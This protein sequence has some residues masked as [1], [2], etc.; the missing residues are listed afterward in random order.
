MKHSI[1]KIFQLIFA[2]A[3]MLVVLLGVVVLV[4]I[5]ERTS[6]QQLVLLQKI[7]QQSNMI[8]ELDPKLASL[9][10]ISF[11]ALRS[12]ASISVEALHANFEGFN[13]LRVIFK[14]PKDVEG[15]QKLGKLLDTFTATTKSYLESDDAART[16][17]DNAM[18][19]AYNR[20]TLHLSAMNDRVVTNEQ[21]LFD[22]RQL[23][24]FAIFTFSIILLFYIRQRQTFILND[25]RSLYGVTQG[26]YQIQTVEVEAIASRFKKAT[27]V[28]HN[29]AYIDPLTQIKNY[30]GL[31]HAFNNSKN[32]GM[33]NALCLCVFEIDDFE[34]LKQKYPKNF[35]EVVLKKVAF[36]L[37]LYEQHNDIAAIVEDSRFVLVLSRN[38]KEEGLEECEKVRQ[39]INETVFKIPQGEKVNVTISGG[40][41]VKPQNKS[42]EASVIYA[43]EVLKKAQQKGKNRIAQLRDYAEK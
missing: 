14:E 25:I 22:F 19:E 3:A 7:Q 17:T 11:A 35:I 37:S 16:Q 8:A 18:K 1:E 38:S 9:S 27:S 13:P 10:L 42:I 36:M 41:I 31:I 6:Q 21:E 39:S 28:Q 29:P 24:V 4:M 33:N 5:S 34:M 26:S 2:S 12:Q 43:V 32:I 15:M 40:F 30:K 23:V 20:L